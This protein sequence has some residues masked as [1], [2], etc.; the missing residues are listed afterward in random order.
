MMCYTINGDIMIIRLILLAVLILING[1]LSASEIAYLSLDKYTISRKRNKKSKKIM[2]MLDDE[3]KFL[4]TIQIGITLAGF[5]ASAFASETFTDI[6]MDKYGILFISENFTE[7]VLMI[8]ITLILS[9]VTLVFGE[10]VPKKIGRS[11]PYKVATLTINFISFIAKLFYPLIFLLTASTKLICRIL[12]IRERK[13]DL[14]EKDIKRI[15]ITGN[16]EGI[17]EEKEKEYILNIFEFN[18]KKAEKIMT[19]KDKVICLDINDSKTMII[20]KIKNSHFTRFPV[21]NNK[22]VVGYINV[23]DF[24]YAHQSG[25]ELRI[26]EILHHTLSFDKEE[27][28]DD[29]FRIM[30]EKHESFSVITD[31]NEF[32]GILTMEDAVEEIVGNIEDEYS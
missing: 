9:Y 18:D 14:T 20:K 32:M 16:K 13:D 22:I 1:I 8:I 24:I 30:Q 27:K 6:L 11:N 31:H 29:I 5:L 12:N 4:S 7:N 25:K 21:L 2:K 17:V 28:I 19:P 10:L 15:I 3:S 26:K 23:K